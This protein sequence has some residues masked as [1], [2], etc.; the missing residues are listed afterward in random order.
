MSSV[1]IL[2]IPTVV[3]VNS[4]YFLIYDY[5]IGQAGIGLAT[6]NMVPISII[7]INPTELNF[8]E[9]SIDSS[10]TMTFTIINTGNADLEVTNISSNEPAFTVI[11]SA[12]VPP[13]SSQEVEVTFTPTE[14][15]QYNGIIELSHNA[16]GSPDTVT[17]TGDGV[18]VPGV[19]DE[20]QPLTFSLEQ[21]YPNPFNPVTM[22]KYQISELSFV[23]IKVYDVL[24][25]EIETLVDEYKLAGTYEVEFNAASH[26]GEVRNLTSGVYFYKLVAGSFVETKKMLLLK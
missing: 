16:Q 4:I 26:S 13:Y 11:T 3:F 9:V 6:A 10:A 18:I 19:E 2:E 17:V 22:I 12:I 23:T 1:G 24:G 25:N 8:G 7:S 20:L 15:I 14:E 21:N 5:G